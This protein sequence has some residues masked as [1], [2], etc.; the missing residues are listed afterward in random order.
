MLEEMG[1][2]YIEKNDWVIPIEIWLAAHISHL[3]PPPDCFVLISSIPLLTGNSAVLD[4]MICNFQTF[5]SISSFQIPVN[6]Q[7]TGHNNTE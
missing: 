3:L 7:I 4:N 6:T 1:G 2:Y 5:P